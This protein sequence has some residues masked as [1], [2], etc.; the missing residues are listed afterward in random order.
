MEAST[1]FEKATIEVLNLRITYILTSASSSKK[2]RQQ[3]QETIT[4]FWYQLN[5]MAYIQQIIP[6]HNKTGYS[7]DILL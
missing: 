4:S 2:N 7:Q 3:K 1:F 6:V 5:A